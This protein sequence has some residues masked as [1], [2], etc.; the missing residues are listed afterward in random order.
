MAM[1]D[2]NKVRGGWR[3]EGGLLGGLGLAGQ[4]TGSAQL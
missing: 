2:K 3:V 1:A 4:A